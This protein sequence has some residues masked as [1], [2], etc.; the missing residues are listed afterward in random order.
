MTHLLKLTLWAVLCPSFAYAADM[1]LAV[2]SA[3]TVTGTAS[4]PDIDGTIR[5]EEYFDGKKFTMTNF[6]S[7]GPS[8]TDAH[9][10]VMVSSA[11]APGW[12][13]NCLTRAGAA[14]AAT[15]LF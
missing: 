1:I 15:T 10:Y 7:N 4:Q 6:G 9:G 8:N 13:S 14:Y 12:T 2:Q 3:P 5:A 11:D